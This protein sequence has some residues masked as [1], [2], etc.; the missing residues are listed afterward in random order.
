MS[1]QDDWT[2]LINGKPREVLQLTFFV[3]VAIW[4]T[5]AAL[6]GVVLYALLIR[7]IQ[8]PWWSLLG[9]GLF[10]VLGAWW[11]VY[12]VEYPGG[13]AA[14]L[15]DGFHLNF[16]LWEAG[17]WRETDTLMTLFS[18]Y[19]IRYLLGFSVFIAG[20][21]GVLGL[22]SNTAQEKH[23]KAL[24]RGN[25]SE[26]PTAHRWKVKKAEQ[27]LEAT[28]LTN[29][30]GTALG[31]SLLNSKPV[32]IPDADVNQM[33]LVLGTTGGGKTITM[34]RFYERA[35][36]QGAPLIAVDGKPTA[37]NAAWLRALA[38]QHGRPFY[39]FNCENHCH[40]NVFASGGYTELKD[41][42][43]SLK[44]EWESDY[45]KTIAEDYLQTA[46]EVL[47]KSGQPFDLRTVADCLEYETLAL[48]AREANDERLFM[49]VQALARYDKKDISGLRAHLNILINS[50]L[51]A[52][53]EINESHTF[54]LAEVIA[55]GGIVYFALP[56]L[57]FPSFAKVLG[58]LVVN[59]IKAVIAHHN[60]AGKKTFVSF[61]EFS[62]FVGLQSLNVVNM[63]RG[64]GIHAIFG[65]QGTAEL[66]AIDPSFEKQIL[67]C[68]N[69][70]ICHRLNDSAS[71]ETVANWAG[72][73]DTFKYTAK[74][75]TLQGNTGDGSIRS[76]K[77]FIIH[78]DEIKQGLAVGE[79]F[80]ITKCGGYRFDKVKVKYS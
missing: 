69:T 65:T 8:L 28:A 24:Q 20:V 80:Y 59:D 3:F 74:V 26:R 39:G 12:S 42:I 46:F 71:A 27:Q 36:S 53:F 75:S 51:G 68:V 22:I 6:V 16:M 2:Q 32:V 62:V 18:D 1:Q 63:G 44:D 41:K 70:I 10:C 45:Y 79:A 50:E 78:P 58:K 19:G 52:Y 7:L 54:N 64:L 37:E 47:L 60:Q 66:G 57:Q 13:M 35:I 15:K 49:R 56:A 73:R 29:L 23:L 77:E 5:S 17:L 9:A 14:F 38:A 25:I 21:L 72:T 61:D 33:V 43:I 11:W 4:Q 55:T 40:Y 30:N 76:T 34:R 67:N 31:V 48:A